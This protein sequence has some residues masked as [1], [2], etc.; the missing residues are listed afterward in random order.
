MQTHTPLVKC[1]A[2]NVRFVWSTDDD[3]YCVYL[4]S[5]SNVNLVEYKVRTV[6][7]HSVS[8]FLT[9]FNKRFYQ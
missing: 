5:V 9:S 2:S 7:I 8:Y 3:E 6:E 1:V 4:L